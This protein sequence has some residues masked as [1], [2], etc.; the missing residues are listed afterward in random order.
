MH[1]NKILHSQLSPSSIIVGSWDL[2]RKDRVVK[3]A[4]LGFAVNSDDTKNVFKDFIGSFD[5]AFVSA[6]LRSDGDPSAED[7]LYSYAAIVFYTLTG[8]E[9]FIS[10][11]IENGNYLAQN[12]RPIETL[13][14]N[15]QPQQAR[16]LNELF[17]EILC[18]NGF[19][20]FN[21][22]QKIAET[23]VKILTEKESPG[24]L[25]KLFKGN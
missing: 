6:N 7:D 20:K 22:A 1:K 18:S 11:D 3:I 14:P 21:S 16:R 8:Q 10:Y 25:Q 9:P 13:M 2:N 5:N 15:L 4:E 23:V 12:L 17:A 19:K 24:L